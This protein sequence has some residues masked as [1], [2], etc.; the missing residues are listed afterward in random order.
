MRERAVKIWL[1][2]GNVCWKEVAW[3]HPGKRAA[4][5]FY[6]TAIY[7]RPIEADRVARIRRFAGAADRRHSLFLFLSFSHFT[8]DRS[9]SLLRPPDWTPSLYSTPS[10]SLSLYFSLTYARSLSLSLG[11]MIFQ[12]HPPLSLP[13]DCILFILNPNGCICV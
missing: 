7:P 13:L 6:P 2:V 11:R 5:S 12:S 4:I 1:R 3:K 8:N 9:A 10:L